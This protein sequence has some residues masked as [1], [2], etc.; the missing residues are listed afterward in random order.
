MI[1]VFGLDG[2]HYVQMI[3]DSMSRAI[4]GYRQSKGV[5][6]E[7][8]DF[9][10]QDFITDIVYLKNGEIEIDETIF[11]KHSIRCHQIASSDKMESEELEKVL[12]QI[13][14]KN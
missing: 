2:L 1:E 14:L 3:I 13:G 10:W 7:N 6:S 5:H 12:N 4:A 8:D 9:E 11:E